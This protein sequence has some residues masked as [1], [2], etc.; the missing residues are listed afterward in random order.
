MED[1]LKVIGEGKLNIKPDTCLISLRISNTLANYSD[2]LAKSQAETSEVK[3]ILEGLGLDRDKLKTRSFNVKAEYESYR[4]KDNNYRNKFIGY[5]YDIDLIF[6]FPIDNELLGK[7]LYNLGKGGIDAKISLSF[8]AKD[9]A[10]YKDECIRLAIKNA[11][12]RA[13]LIA[14]EMEITL[15]KPLAI[16][17]SDKELISD[18]EYR[19]YDM[20]NTRCLLSDSSAPSV[21]I[22]PMDIEVSSSIEL[23]YR[24]L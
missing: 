3:D 10:F 20:L 15:G 6:K 18:I 17:Y 24:L 2:T 9:E 8:I 16:N 21:D 19:S 1:V 14:R 7:I 23:S 12:N 13:K 5:R 11:K 4:D 22:E